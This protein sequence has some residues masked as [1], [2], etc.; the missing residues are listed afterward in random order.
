[1]VESF[2]ATP[3]SRSAQQSEMEAIDLET[4]SFDGN[5]FDLDMGAFQPDEF[6][7][8]EA[9]AAV[10]RNAM[11]Q[12]H[13]KE[14]PQQEAG[15]ADC[16]SEGKKRKKEGGIKGP[17]RRRKRNK[18]KPRRP[19]V[20]YNIFFQKHS[21]EIKATTLFKDLGRVMGERWK[22]LTDQQRAVY[23]KEAEKDVI[24][25]RRE[26]D[27][28]E[29]KRKERLNNNSKIGTATHSTSHLSSPF[30]Q[31]GPPLPTTT[32]LNPPPGWTANSTMATMF[33]FPSSAAATQNTLNFPFGIQGTALSAAGTSPTS[34]PPV[35]NTGLHVPGQF[36][37]TPPNTMALPHG[38]EI[39][40]PD[41]SGGI[42]KYRVVYACYRMTQDE[43][44]DYM[45]R[46]ASVTAGCNFQQ[47]PSSMPPP[48][49]GVNPMNAG[50][51]HLPPSSPQT[52]RPCTSQPTQSAPMDVPQMVSW[53]NN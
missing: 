31:K 45:A 51:G 12:K 4:G 43:A 41:A 2:T 6:F 5:V 32:S 22:S 29:K 13:I 9:P 21:D 36:I 1:M 30:S 39:F 7:E 27:L 35:Q 18:D 28:Y 25:F 48:A 44:N 34:P 52:S 38:S 10:S 47:S 50:H 33:S 19:L 3:L 15:K 53:L 16:A 11:E 14:A 46:F 42:R 24:R 23:E 8:P 26:M 20:G 40:L 17:S 37:G 49:P